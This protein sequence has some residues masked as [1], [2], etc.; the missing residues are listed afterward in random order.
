[1]PTSA[2]LG[3]YRVVAAEAVV[4]ELAHE[5]VLGAGH[6]ALRL[7]QTL[8]ALGPEE[9]DV[10]QVLGHVAH[11]HGRLDGGVARVHE[12]HDLVALAHHGERLVVGGLVH[13]LQLLH[14]VERLDSDEGLRQRHRPEAR[15]EEEEAA[16]RVDVEEA[17]HVLELDC[18]VS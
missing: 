1:M 17:G 3:A 10:A 7:A 14:L 18:T 8:V 9:L 15:V 2:H 11:L 13:L 5:V 12:H 16:R 6:L 4:E